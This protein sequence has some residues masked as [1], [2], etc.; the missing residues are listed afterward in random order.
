MVASNVAATAAGAYQSYFVKEDGTLWAMGSNSYGSLGNGTYVDSNSASNVVGLIVGRLGFMASAFNTLAVC[1]A[2]PQ[3]ATLANQ[4]VGTSYPF[5][6][7]LNVTNGDGPFTYQWQLN[8]AN[9]SGATNASYTVVSATPGNAGTYTGIATGMAGSASLSAT[10]TVTLPPPGITSVPAGGVATLGQPASLSVTAPDAGAAY[11]W[12]KDGVKLVSQTNSTLA[13]ASFQITDCGSYQVAA[14]TGASLNISLPAFL[15]LAGPTLKGWGQNFANLL[16]LPTSQTNL[17]ATIGSNVV[18]MGLGFATALLVSSDGTLWVSGANDFG[19]LG[20]GTTNTIHIR[21]NVASNAVSAAGG[22]SYSLFVKSDGTLWTMGKNNYGQLGN[23]TTNDSSVPVSVAS[24]VVA[25]AAGGSHCLFIKSDGTLWGIGYN[26]FGQLGNGST[27]NAKLPVSVASNVVAVAA[28]NNHSLFVKADGSLWAMG[29]NGYGQ[30]GITPGIY[31]TNRPAYVASNVAGVTAGFYHSLFVKSDG[32]LWAMGANALGR[33]GNGTT[34]DALLPVNIASNVVQAVGG[35]YCSVFEKS[36]GTLWGMGANPY[37]ELGIGNYT[38]QVWPVQVPNLT[39][40]TLASGPISYITMAVGLASPQAA[41]LASQTVTVG[42]PF[43]FALVLTGGDGPFTYQWQLNG[44]NISEATNASYTVAASTTAD[45]GAYTGIITGP[46]GS[47]SRS[48]T[49]TVNPGVITPVSITLG[50]LSQTYDGTAHVPGVNTSPSGV[51]VSLTY[52][53]SASAPVNA[54][55]YTVVATVTSPGYTGGATNTL[56]IAKA[57]Q[58]I[59]IQPLSSSI[60]LNQ[61]T[62]P[63]PVLATASSGLPVTLA[64]DAGSA[65]TLTGGNLLENIGQTGTVTLRANQAGN[66]N[67]LAATEAGLTLDVTK[68]NQTITFGAP[69]DQVA[70]NAPLTLSATASS[71]LEVTYSVVSGPASLSGNQLSLTGAGQV[72]VAASQ[73]G[74]GAYN[75]ANPVN[76]S[77]TVTLASQAITFG[78]LAD[79]SCGDAPFALTGSAGSSLAVS[80]VSADTNVVA[81]SGST[82]TVVGAGTATIT[83]SQPGNDFYAAAANASQT[84]TVNQATPSVTTWPTASAISEGQALS[85]SILSGGTA[86]VPGGFT[87]AAPATIPPLGTNAQSVVFTPTAATNYLS[88]TG[89]VNVIVNSSGPVVRQPVKDG[90]WSDPATW[91]GTLPAVGDDVVIPAGITVT[92]DGDTGPIKNLTIIGTLTVPASQTLAV[93]GNFT[94]SGTFT[95]GTGTVALVGGSNQVLA[96]T[97]PG[98]LTFYKLTENKDPATASVTATSKLKVSKKLTLTSG[99]LYSASDYGDV[100][101]ETASALE[102]TSDITIGGDLVVQGDGELITA[103]HTVTFD[104]GVVQNLTLDYWVA[105]D[106]L[107]VTTNTTLVETESA[108]NVIVNGTLLNQGVIRKAQVLDATEYYYF[109]LAGSYASADMEIHV[110]DRTGGAPL[111]AIQVDRVDA[112][113]A[114]A[115]GTNT[116]GIYWTITPTGSDFVANVALPQ[117]GLDDPQ[118]CRYHNSTWDWARSAFDPNTVTRTNLTAFGDFAV[119]NDPQAVVSTTTTLASSLNPT[120]YGTSVTFTSTVSP[121]VA[122]GTVTFKDGST[123]LGTG[124]LSAGVATFTTSGLSVGAHSLTAEYGGDG[125]YSS[126][127]S[128]P[129]TQTVAATPGTHLYDN[130]GKTPF[131]EAMYE[132]NTWAASQFTTDAHDYLLKTVVL[133]MYRSGPSTAQLDIYSDAGGGPG[134]SLGTLTSPEDIPLNTAAEVTFITAGISLPASST[135]WVVLRAPTGQLWWSYTEDTNGTGVGFSTTNTYSEDAGASWSSPVDYWPNQLQINADLVPVPEPSALALAS[136]LSPSTY[137]SSVTFTATVSPSAATGT[138]TFKDGTN[139]LG[140]SPLSGGVATFTTNGLS[141]GSRSLT[142]EYA[143]DSSYSGSTNSP[144]TQTV[145]QAAASVTLTNLVQLYNGAARS[146]TATTLPEG[147]PVALTYD[148]SASA[149]TN[150]GAYTVTATITD[151]NY[152]GGA[153]NTLYIATA[154]EVQTVAQEGGNI[155]F[156]WSAQAGLN[157]QVSCATNLAP[158]VVWTDLGSPVTATNTV[159]TTTEAVN[160]DEAMR[161]YRVRLVLP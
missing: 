24:S 103:G 110:T 134:T 112:N 59:T 95:P 101:I 72:T 97:A 37:G 51:N 140:A 57:A 9:I 141:A 87:F 39:A 149:P 113:P 155:T 12:F 45:A 130:L 100:L 55:N 126:S 152:I 1:G 18:A 75:P 8:G 67:Y 38:S 146:A 89:A 52:D 61:F 116:T 48:A 92:L 81:I 78:S 128:S 70:T 68:G 15:S 150:V 58:S 44:T 157:Y 33:L 158:P 102:L 21:T 14:G 142:A 4:V 96:A 104:G 123:T 154:P 136:S 23:G 83:A 54:G 122:T 153:T 148:G 65:A 20:N 62:D 147:L 94:N 151:P 16:G 120:T 90:P 119:F 25:A 5:T 91:G 160:A 82:V 86:S 124:T 26:S 60:P 144:L 73:A 127:V 46:A 42:Q 138:V 131:T 98:T 93:S 159:M 53:G 71:S 79:R 161:L 129:L 143:G 69:A 111:T 30:L 108:N 125:S 3:L 35:N 85:S 109:G 31:S 17:P 34:V 77:F 27:A 135:Y 32:T 10:L 56:V 43:T 66:S 99:K 117:D 7:S 118:V 50:N 115:P 28:G 156:G 49:L 64:L 106:D 114:N 132:S 2:V 19:Q 63:I 41:S 76:Q 40:G 36:D 84:L 29:F 6:F 22:T 88:V 107:T 139:T 11:Q 47:A 74:N 80:Y 13:V 145:N 137:G 133:L 105:F 121:S